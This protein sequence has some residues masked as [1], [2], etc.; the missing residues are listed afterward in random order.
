MNIW[1][2]NILR[3]LIVMCLQILLINNLQLWGL[4]SPCFYLLFLFALPPTLPRWAE[5]IIGAL[6][7]LIIDIFTNTL[8]VN[9][10][11]C[12]LVSYLRP[13]FIKTMI[14]DND[15]LTDTLNLKTVTPSVYI[16]LIT[17]LIAIHHFVLFNLE[18]F[19][20]SNWWLTLIHIVLSSIATLLLILLA[21]ILVD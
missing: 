14:Q 6:T 5:L 7:G 17:I 13:I 20:L 19:S 9:M 8:G 1:I 3:F 21:D 4:C 15:R 10:A 11:A 16:R 12:I 2:K 18:A